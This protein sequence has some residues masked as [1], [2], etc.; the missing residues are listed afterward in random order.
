MKDLSEAET[1][2]KIVDPILERV[3]WKVGGS[4]VKEEVNPVKSNFKTKEYLGREL[5]IEKGVDRFIDYL[6][7]DEDKSPVAIV[8][9]KKTSIDVEKEKFKL[10]LIEKI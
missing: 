7:L 4:Y 1:R 6:L 8:E 9:C 2:K 3:G 5:G 10:E